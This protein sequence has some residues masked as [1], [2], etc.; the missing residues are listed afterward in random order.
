MRSLLERGGHDNLDVV[1]VYDLDT[2]ES[3]LDELR[4]VAGDKLDLVPYAKPFNFS[5]KCNLGVVASYGEIVVLLNDDI[6]IE[7]GRTSSAGC[8][9]RCSTTASA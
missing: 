4:A 7:S 1:V 6:E 3:V 2:P 9:A 5:E 8:A